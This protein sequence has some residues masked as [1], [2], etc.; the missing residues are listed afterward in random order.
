MPQYKIHVNGAFHDVQTESDTPIL[1]VLRNDLALNGPKY[2]CG[3]AQC[4]ACTILVDGRATRSCVTPI[5]AIGKK[6]MTTLE[7]LG[8]PDHLD[9]LQKAFLDEQ[10]AQC[11]YCSNGMIITA[12]ALLNKNP[13]PSE[14]EIRQALNAHLCRCGTHNRVIRAVQRA[15]GRLNEGLVK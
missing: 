7:G 8:N 10:A 14:T 6:K 12:K 13:H 5:S 15:A 11:G 4:G 3:V 9:P 1:Y 2:G